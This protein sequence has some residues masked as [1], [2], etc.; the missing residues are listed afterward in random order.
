[1]RR[2]TTDTGHSEW[3]REIQ[4]YICQPGY[5]RGLIYGPEDRIITGFHCIKLQ[6]KQSSFEKGEK[7]SCISR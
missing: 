1:M 4:S 7:K 6:L 5:I 3:G 2:S